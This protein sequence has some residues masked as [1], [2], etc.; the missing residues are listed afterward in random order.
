MNLTISDQ[1][2][3]CNML[4]NR[5][6]L[7]LIQFLLNLILLFWSFKDILVPNNLFSLYC[8]Y[9]YIVYQIKKKI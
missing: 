1:N 6:R 3:L 5:S 8:A 4:H 2:K 9:I 7:T